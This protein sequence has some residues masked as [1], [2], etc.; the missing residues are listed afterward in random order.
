MLATEE[1]QEKYDLRNRLQKRGKKT[2]IKIFGIM[3]QEKRKKT[4]K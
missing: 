4:K 3:V 1:R 2:S